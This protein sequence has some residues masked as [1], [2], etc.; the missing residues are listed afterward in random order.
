[1]VVPVV[2]G[3]E[4]GPTLGTALTM[5]VPSLGAA[6]EITTIDD[7]LGKWSNVV[8]PVVAGR[9]VE[10]ALGATLSMVVGPA[11]GTALEITAIDVPLG[12]WSNVVVPVVAGRVTVTMDELAS[13]LS[14]AAALPRSG[15]GTVQL[16]TNG[17]NSLELT[18]CNKESSDHE[19]KKVHHDSRLEEMRRGQ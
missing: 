8:V 7:P 9:E 3:R 5:V 2:A 4:V 14:I 19:S 17:R 12:K 1:M 10:L 13:L 6:L 15:T 16:W 18:T 11:L